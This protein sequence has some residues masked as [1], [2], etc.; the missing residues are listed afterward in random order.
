MYPFII[1]CAVLGGLIGSVPFF[2]SIQNVIDNAYANQSIGTEF[3]YILS[4]FKNTELSV[5]LIALAMLVVSGL[6]V[7]DTFIGIGRAAR[8]VRSAF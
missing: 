2:V 8:H 5:K 6:V 3:V 7:R 4:A 1:E